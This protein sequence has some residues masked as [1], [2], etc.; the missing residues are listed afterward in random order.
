MAIFFSLVAVAIIAMAYT[1]AI[2]TLALGAAAAILLVMYFMNR[3]GVRRLAGY[4]LLG[5]LLWYA[6]L[7]SRV[8]AT[9]AGV[10]TAAVIPIKPT[11][12][13]P[14]A[15]DL[16]LHKLG[17]CRGHSPNIFSAAS[18]NPRR[19]LPQRLPLVPAR[20]TSS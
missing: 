16:P 7:L 15:G 9:V 6:I 2:N 10:L 18:P 8:H 4:L 13:E 17:D 19:P 20:G 3:S 11:P 14:D 5:L 12:G 1:A